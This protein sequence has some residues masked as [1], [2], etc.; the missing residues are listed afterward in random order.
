MWATL[1]L[2]S[3]LSMAPGQAGDLQLTNDRVTYG[4]LGPTRPDKKFL[5]GDIYLV[6]FD[7]EG[8]KFEGGQAQYRMK[9]DLL[10]AK[11]NSM[12]KTLEQDRDLFAIQGGGRVTLNT[13]AEIKTDT[14][15]GTYTMKLSVT[16]L[17][18]KKT[19][20]LERKFE[21][22]AK[23]FAVVRVH[24]AYDLGG[25]LPAPALGVVGQGLFL[26]FGVTGFGRDPKTKQP[27]IKLEMSMLDEK[28]N[29]TLDKPVSEVVPEAKD[30]VPENFSVLPLWFSLALTRP[31]KYTVKLKAT[32]LT[33]G[34]E[35]S[36]SYPLTVVE[37]PAK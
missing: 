30:E 34:K 16:D 10:D 17:K 11:G 6:T 3:A 23:E 36:A 14:A 25:N 27:K 15:P 2:M 13:H 9:M 33:S 31:G 24:C 19:A 20:T 8:L 12:F 28:G 18:A 1:T 21:V 37:L 5:P 35:A 4:I 22:A 32:D 7:M 29:P 26:H